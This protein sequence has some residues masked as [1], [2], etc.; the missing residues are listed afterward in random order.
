MRS[1]PDARS[2]RSGGGSRP[3]AKRGTSTR[4]STTRQLDAVAVVTPVA[5]HYDLAMRALEAGKHV[6]VE[7]P[8]AASSGRG[9]AI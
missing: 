3:C 7:K 4:C 5:T 6:F 8:L 2:T 1:A 9:A